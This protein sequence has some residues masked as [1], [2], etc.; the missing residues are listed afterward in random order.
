MLILKECELAVSRLEVG[1]L[2]VSASRLKRK[3]QSSYKFYHAVIDI[4]L[5]LLADD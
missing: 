3:I 4:T 5:N 2:Q 1:R